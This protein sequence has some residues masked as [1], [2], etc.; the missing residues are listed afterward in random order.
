MA[1]ARVIVVDAKGGAEFES[2]NDAVKAAVDGDVLQV[3]SGKYDEVLK[4]DRAVM[5]AAD[6][7]AEIGDVLVLGGAVGTA[8]GTVQGI[9]FQSMVDVRKGHLT[10]VSCDISQGSDGVRVCTGA[11]ATISRCH[12]HRAIGDR[13]GD[14]VYVQPGGKAR[15]EECELDHHHVN[16]VHCNGGEVHVVKCNIHDCEFGVYF[17]EHGRGGVEGSTI[18]EIGRIGVYIIKGSDP[19]VTNNRVA[20]CKVSGV[21]VSSGG[22]GSIKDNSVT[23]NVRILQGCSPVLGANTISGRFDNENTAVPAGSGFPPPA[24]SPISSVDA[25]KQS[26]AP[27]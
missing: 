7:N 14:G 3:R 22:S 20:N 8:N 16:G 24:A 25:R 17:R 1:D 18:D 26:V 12:I 6:P 23:G 13:G 19:A 4:V 9:A 10:L 2:I 15:V 27:R 21:M 11:E 5:I